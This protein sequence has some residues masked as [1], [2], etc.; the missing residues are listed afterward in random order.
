V[1]YQNEHKILSKYEHSTHL[2]QIACKRAMRY[3][4]KRSAQ[5]RN[6]GAKGGAIPRAWVTMGAPKVP[7]MS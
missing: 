4:Q 1:N 5:G 6:E 3:A 2:I 7:T